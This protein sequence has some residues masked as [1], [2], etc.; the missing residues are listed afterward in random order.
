[1][2]SKTIMLITISIIC[3]LLTSVMFVQFKTIEVV[4][5]S[6]IGD[7][8]ETELRT[9]LSV[10]KSKC[11]EVEASLAENK[12]LLE[13]YNN[14]ITN[15]KSSVE[16]LKTELAKLRTSVGYT[17]VEGSGIVITVEDNENRVTADDLLALVYELKYVGA[18]AISINDE[19]IV[20]VSDIVDIDEKFIFVNGQRL[21]SPFTI[22]AIGDVS[23]L[24]SAISIKGGYKDE[25]E[26]DG[27]KVSY[28]IQDKVRI[29]KY[30]GVMEINYGD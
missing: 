10:W 21:I 25:L 22:K 9:E 7:M 11:E 19:R 6:G 18:E 15:D 4:Q 20:T 24:E 13:Q 17:A 12:E 5:K 2:K 26:A 29:E 27:K 30:N 8:R 3:I 16:L 28:K 23:Y 1:M 14:E